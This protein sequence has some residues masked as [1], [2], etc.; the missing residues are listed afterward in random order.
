MVLRSITLPSLAA[1]GALF[2]LAILCTAFAYL[3]YFSLLG[4]VGGTKAI[5]VTFLIPVFGAFWGALFINESI[6]LTMITGMVVILVGTALVT[7]V[8][9]LR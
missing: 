8:A 3:L 5:T 7:G 9:K 4:E 2:A 6:T 1:W